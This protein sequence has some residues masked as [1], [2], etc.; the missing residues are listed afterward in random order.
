MTERKIEQF[1][2]DATAEDATSG[3]HLVARFRNNRKGGWA[4]RTLSGWRRTI[5]E[6]SFL[7]FDEAGIPWRQCQVYDPPQWFLDKFDPG[8]GFRLLEKFPNE[9]KLATDEAWNCHLREWKQTLTDHS[10]Q[11]KTVWYRRRIEPNNPEK[12]DSCVAYETQIDEVIQLP[13][14]KRFKVTHAGFEVL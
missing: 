12:L 11:S 13:S 4:D 5:G 1:W 14:G 9:P 2:R 3:K 10:D 7:F 8:E 6:P